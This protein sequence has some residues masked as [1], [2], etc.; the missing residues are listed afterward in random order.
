MIDHVKHRS[1][2]LIH[3]ATVAQRLRRWPTMAWFENR[4]TV[5]GNYRGTVIKIAHGCGS[6]EKRDATVGGKGIYS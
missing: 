2:R 3:S 6:F 4:S 5:L 1:R